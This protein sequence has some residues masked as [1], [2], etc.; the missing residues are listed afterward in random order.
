M[1]NT[2][3]TTIIRKLGKPGCTPCVRLTLLTRDM[4]SEL[5]ELGAVISEHD[6][7]VETGLAGKYNLDSV[8]VLIFER[9]GEEFARLNGMVSRDEIISVITQ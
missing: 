6:T 1:T 4:E 8:P 3:T 2:N 9:D 7:S 5:K